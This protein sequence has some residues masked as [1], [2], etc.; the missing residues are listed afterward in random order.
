MLNLIK[1]TDTLVRIIWAKVSEL[2]SYI[3]IHVKKLIHS[4]SQMYFQWIVLL[5]APTKSNKV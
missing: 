3:I 1:E 2:S 4:K 5:Q